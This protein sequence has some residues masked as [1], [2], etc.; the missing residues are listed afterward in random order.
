MKRIVVVSTTNNP[1][2][3]FYAKYVEHAWNKLGWDLCIMITDGV[4]PLNLELSNPSTTIVQLPKIE[5]IREETIAQAGRLYAANYLPKDALIMTSDIDLIPLSD[6][7]NPDI[8]NVTIYGHDLTWRTYFPMGYC[9]MSGENWF[10]HL[11]CTYDTK[12]DL[13]RDVDE[14]GLARSN[15]WEQWWNHDWSLLTKRLKELGN[16]L[17]FI[18]RGQVNIAGATLA[19]GRIDRYNWIET[20]KQD[21]F[22]DAHCENVNVKHPVKL[23]P[24]LEMWKKFYPEL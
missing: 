11:R 1:D 2:Y 6:Y 5:G 20:Q 7:W 19:K 23:E 16:G 4:D 9:A 15:D 10:K 12:S 14:I 8:N 24:F 3:Y 13:L 17:T 22:I 21:S 18:D